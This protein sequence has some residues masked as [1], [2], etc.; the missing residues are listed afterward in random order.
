[1]HI[2]SSAPSDRRR[3]RTVSPA[4]PITYAEVSDEELYQAAR[5]VVSAEIAKIHTIEW[6]TQLLYDDPLFNAM[7]S[8]WS[9]VFDEGSRLSAISERFRQGVTE[10]SNPDKSNLLGSIFASGSGIVGSGSR[11][12]DPDWNLANLGDV[13]GGVNHFGSPFNFPEEFVTVYRLHA[14]VPDLIDFREVDGDRNVIQTKVPVVETAFAGATTAMHDGGLANWALS[15]GRQRL[16]ALTLG[17]HPQF[18]QNLAV[19]RFQSETGK[20]DV[21]ALDIIRDRERGIPRFNEFRRQYG[22]KR[23]NTFEELVGEE[24]ADR[25]WADDL[26]DIYGT[27]TCDASKIITEAQRYQDEEASLEPRL[28]DDGAGKPKLIDD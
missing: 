6:T 7:N 16:G 21:A 14:L 5:L 26:R 10:S 17:N 25:G 19:P 13:N 4:A 15:M 28:F 1:M 24:L 12:D 11:L 8:N 9:G 22:L 18:L 3:K 27:H 23:F 20:I 2:R